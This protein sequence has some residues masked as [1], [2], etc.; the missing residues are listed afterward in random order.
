[1]QLVG[2]RSQQQIDDYYGAADPHTL[3]PALLGTATTRI[4]YD[5][6]Q[7]LNSQTAAPT[8]PTQWQPVFTSTIDSCGE[9]SAEA[10]AAALEGAAAAQRRGR[11]APETGWGAPPRKLDGSW[12]EVRA[13]L[14]GAPTLKSAPLVFMKV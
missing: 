3:A 4:V 1:M 8:D 10:A 5:L 14:L 11:A 13:G 6:N 12:P 2:S 9:P 7:F